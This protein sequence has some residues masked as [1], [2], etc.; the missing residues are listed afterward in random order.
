MDLKQQTIETYNKSA[1]ALTKKFNG[2]GG[3]GEEITKIFSLIPKTN[4]R[5]IEIGCGNGRDAEE[6]LKHTNE[7]VGIDISEKLI[8]IARSRNPHAKFEVADVETYE[9]G[10]RIDA[11]FAFASLIHVPKDSLKAV[12]SR[13]CNAMNNGGVVLATLKYSPEYKTSTKEDEFGV[14]TYYLY[15]ENDVNE[16]TGIFKSIV[17]ERYELRGQEWL[18]IVLKK[19]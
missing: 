9:F 19:A 12:F 10:N 3:Y 5:T 17:I 1:E 8:A 13:L 7:Y 6:I 2:Q 18:K 11:V 15:S 4:P 16:I 14:R